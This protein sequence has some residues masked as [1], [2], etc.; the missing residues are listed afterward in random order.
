[1][2]RGCQM[3]RTLRPVAHAQRGVVLFIALIVLVALT[4]AGIALVR[5]V[6]T[7]NVI[8]G[9]L[10]FKQGT[11]Q[12]GDLGIEAAVT[13][14]PTIITTTSDAVSKPA[15]STTPPSFWY[16]PTRRQ[17]DAYG[18]PTDTAV[19]GG[20]PTAIDW[21]QVPIADSRAGN[22][23]RV[24]IDRLCQGTLPITDIEKDCLADAPLV[25]GSKKVGATAFT[26]TTT[27]YYR[28]TARVS[29][30]RNTVSVVQ[31]ILSR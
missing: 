3:I 29:G 23:V 6:D 11:L 5:S 22:D 26:A 8:A 15:A 1:M 9:N 25:G 20:T 24:V 7:T 31:A 12:A 4:L 27:V 28:V 2:N 19:G 21:T 17:T 18:V 30:P 16:Y 14:L 10:A 13:A